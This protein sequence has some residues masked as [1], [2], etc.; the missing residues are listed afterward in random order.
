MRF[1]TTRFSNLGMLGAILGQD[2]APAITPSPAATMSYQ[3]VWDTL[4]ESCQAMIGEEQC[5]RLLGR[6]CFLC[7]PPTGTPFT[8]QWW[9]WL[10]LGIAGGAIVGKL[11]Q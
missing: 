5:I 11:F 9:F 1:D 10:G 2:E 8:Q 3:R 4:Q 7:P 6:T